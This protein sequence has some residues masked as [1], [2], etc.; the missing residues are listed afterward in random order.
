M[1]QPTPISP[2]TPAELFRYTY[3]YRC[4]FTELDV[5]AEAV[6][7]CRERFG[8]PDPHYG[9]PKRWVRYSEVEIAFLDETDAME[10]KMRWVG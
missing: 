7:W 2:R 6:L 10:F 8:A 4:G 9:V 3:R 5:I 1:F